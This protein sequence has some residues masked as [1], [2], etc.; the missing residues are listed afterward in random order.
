MRLH[1]TARFATVI[2]HPDGLKMMVGVPGQTL[3]VDEVTAAA[4]L[5]DV[6]GCL[7][8]EQAAKIAEPAVVVETVPVPDEV[9]AA[10]RKAATRQVA[11][12]PAAK[13]SKKV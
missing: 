10:P 3:D 5:R 8:L 9:V 6:P 7:T 1:V 2:T 4:L 12:K 11:R 13:R